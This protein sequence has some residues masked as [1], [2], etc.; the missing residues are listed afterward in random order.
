MD[1]SR[2]SDES[3]GV[4]SAAAGAGSGGAKRRGVAALVVVNAVLLGLLAVVEFGPVATAQPGVQDPAAARPRGK[5]TLVGGAVQT[6]NANAVYIIDSSNQEM[7][8]LQWEDGRNVLKGVGY[9][10]LE[11]DTQGRSQR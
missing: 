8:V 10:D 9:R 6:G 7:V 1:C 11:A 2:A 4:V 3:A 5:Y